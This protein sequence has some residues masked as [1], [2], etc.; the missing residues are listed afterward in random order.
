MSTVELSTLRLP[1]AQ[2]GIDPL[3]PLRATTDLH[4]EAALQNLPDAGVDEEM[5]AGLAYGKVSSVLPYLPQSEYGRELAEV[6]HPVAVLDNG[7]LRATFLLGWGGRLWS[8]VDVKTGR[9]LLYANAALQPGNLALRDAWFAGGVEWNL[10]TTGHHP[11]TC[12]PLHAATI[13]LPDGTPGL[14]LWEYERMRE[15]VL[16]LDAWLPADA[17]RLAVM[18]TVS[19]VNAHDVP[20]YW[21]SNIAVPQRDGT[22]VLT[23]ATSAYRFDYSR[24]LRHIPMP[25]VSGVDHSYPTNIP[26][27]VDYFFDLEPRGRPWIAAVDEHGYGLLQT[28]S[29]RLRGRK[30]FVW[31]TGDGG[32]R[33]QHWLSPRGG[34]YLEIQAGLAR[35]Q[36]E[37]LPLPAGERWSWLETYGPVTISD[38][39]AGWAEATSAGSAQV[40]AED[41][42]FATQYALGL[43]GADRPIEQRLHRG[44]GWGALE[45]R[46]RRPAGEPSPSLPGTPFLDEDLGPDQEPWLAILDGEQPAWDGSA[47]TSCQT[48]PGW[49]ALLERRAGAYAAYQRGVAR[50]LA[51]D[52]LGAVDAWDESLRSQPSAVAWRNI[53]VAYADD[54][55][56]RALSAYREAR[57]LAPTWSA[58]VI[59]QLQLLIAIGHHHAVLAEVDLLP[60][61]LRREPR[62]ALCEAQSAVAVGDA[63]RAGAILEPGL[64]IP[65]LREGTETLGRLWIDYQA[66]IVG[67]EAAETAEL[68]PAYDFR[69][70]P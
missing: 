51:G 60:E 25:S 52:R 54:D 4:Q 39:H 53:A 19:N 55:H 37:H 67:R 36:L 12:E 21:W 23:P 24:T 31:G 64:E 27:A 70:R 20:V 40:L 18:I 16:Q 66:L 46:R 9:E 13:S 38:A 2:V 10:G 57:T 6:E 68:P 5:A 62:I 30:L 44:S 22:R 3:P 50:W 11:L 28:S 61:Q 35:T 49:R 32:H 29:A 8:L 69:M 59:E 41:G 34:E 26:H 58:L 56:Q 33:W 15:L 7:R 17:D 48:A 47:P 42:W 63:E 43:A 1:T 45:V 65:Q 14:R